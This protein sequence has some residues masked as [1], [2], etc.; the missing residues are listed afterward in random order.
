MDNSFAIKSVWNFD[1]AEFMAIYSIKEQCIELF[2]S[3]NMEDLYWM[4]RALRREIDAKLD[5]KE[6]E[7]V[8]E[9]L[10]AI[11]DM[12]EKILLDNDSKQKNA[13]YI[14]LEDFY[15]L[16][17]DLMKEHGIYFREGDDPRRAALKR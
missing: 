8:A 14:K 9:E 15:L 6:K 11:V 5:V 16:L 2:S 17:C 13:F 3:Q 1:E 7:R 10:T 4:L 12:R